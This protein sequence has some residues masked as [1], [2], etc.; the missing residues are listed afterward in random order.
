MDGV[1][2]AGAPPEQAAQAGHR[3][4]RAGKHELLVPA[5]PAQY[6]FISAMNV[7]LERGYGESLSPRCADRFVIQKN[8]NRVDLMF[9]GV[10]FVRL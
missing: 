2:P 5:F 7:G 1:R 3:G 4:R 6:P 9:P 8:E 10:D